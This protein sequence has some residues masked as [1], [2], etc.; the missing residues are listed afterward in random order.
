VA[1]TRVPS[2]WVLA[3][4]AV[5]LLGGGLTTPLAVAADR[6]N[7]PLKNW[8]GFSIVRDAVY[9]DLERLVTAGLADRTLL[10]TKPLSRIE[11]ARIVAR[12][13]EKIRRDEAGEYNA[14]RDLEPV[15][16]RLKEEFRTELASLGLRLGDAPAEA[17]GAVS[18]TPVDRGQVSGAYASRDPRLPNQQGLKFHQGANGGST[19]ESRLQVGDYLT[20]YLQPWLHGNEDFAAAGLQTGYAKLTLFN[21]E[22]LVGRDS[23]WWGP[24]LH[25]S[26][27]M[28]NNAAPLDQIRLGAAE[29]FQLPLIGPWLGPMKILAFL[30]ELEPDRDYRRAKLAG[31]RATIAPFSFLEL[32]ISRAVMFDGDVSPRPGITDYPKVLFNPSAGDQ[33]PTDPPQGNRFRNNNLFA[34]DAD[35]RLKNVYKYFV[36]AHDARLYGEFGWDDTCCNSN[37]I[38]KRSALSG[39][40]GVQYLGLFEREGLDARVEWV[41]TSTESFTHAQFY[42]GYWT[43]GNVISDV[44]GTDGSDYYARV[45]QRFTPNLMAG[46]E[47]DRA[48]IGNTQLGFAGPT[49]HRIGGAVD[50]SWRFWDKYSL[51]AQYQL[52]HVANRDFRTGNDGY[53]NLFRVELTR[54]FR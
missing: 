14:R 19:F 37:F 3:L 49:E 50:L 13:I 30:A 51:F 32:G 17:P 11:A 40:I 39:L 16:D 2:L 23:L 4:A 10:S 41:R 24:A 25:G 44:A 8:G 43:R 42:R 53:E 33:K 35:L 12:A 1:L 27:I 7:I 54:S 6:T 45:T 52:V 22:L 28:S 9:D 38:P 18:F 29:P 47:I 5:A 21:T 34:V 36:P 31:M 26:L 20:F 46:V 15:L 48:V